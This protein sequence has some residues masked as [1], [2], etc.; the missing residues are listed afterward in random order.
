MSHTSTDE[1]TALPLV[2]TPPDPKPC[3]CAHDWE[4]H[5]PEAGGCIEC[6]CRLHR[7]QARHF[8]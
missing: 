5:G 4:R 8:R 7:P 3:T 2:D 6:R 1:V